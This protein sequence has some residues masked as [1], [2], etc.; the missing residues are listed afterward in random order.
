MS[1]RTKK[2]WFGFYKIHLPL[3][4][5]HAHQYYTYVTKRHTV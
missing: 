3:V 2:F 5:K 4:D 1:T